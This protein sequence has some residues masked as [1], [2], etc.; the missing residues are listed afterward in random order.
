MNDLDAIILSPAHKEWRKVAR[1][2]VLATA[3][4][5]VAPTEDQLEAVVARVRD[6]VARGRLEVKG[7]LSRSRFSEARLPVADGR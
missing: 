2:A 6:L 1:I 5:G 4:C 3:E 7:D